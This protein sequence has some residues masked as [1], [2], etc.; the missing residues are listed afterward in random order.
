MA[1]RDKHGV[2][3]RGMRGNIQGGHYLEQ[4]HRHK[5]IPAKTFFCRAETNFPGKAELKIE[6]S[7]DKVTDT[8]PVAPHGHMHKTP[9]T[10]RH[11]YSPDLHDAF[12][13]LHANVVDI[14]PPF[15]FPTHFI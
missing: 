2:G 5:T 6:P 8:Y 13:N 1:I 12:R 7:A 9:C 10:P 15:A 14:Q 11:P 4:F 3:R